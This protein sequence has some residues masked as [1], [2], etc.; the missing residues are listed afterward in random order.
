MFF[1]IHFIFYIKPEDGRLGR[2]M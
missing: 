1:I 2:N